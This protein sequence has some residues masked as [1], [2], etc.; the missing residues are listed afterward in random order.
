MTEGHF[1]KALRAKKCPRAVGL[2]PWPRGCLLFTFLFV[3]DKLLG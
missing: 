3:R 2:H 1:Q